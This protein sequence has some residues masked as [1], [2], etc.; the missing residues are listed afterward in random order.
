MMVRFKFKS[1]AD[2]EKVALLLPAA[3]KW[4]I[5]RDQTSDAYLEVPEDYEDYI[6]RYLIKR[7][8]K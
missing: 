6:Y 8:E 7:D 4:S 1:A 5:L 2:A 3:C